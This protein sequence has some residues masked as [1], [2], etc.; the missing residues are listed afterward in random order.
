M[1]SLKLLP[2]IYLVIHALNWLEI[3]PGDARRETATWEQWP[4]RCEICYAYEQPLKEKYHALLGRPDDSSAVF[5]MPSGMAGD[6]P[7]IALAERT[8]GERCLV[9]PLGYD[10]G[11]NRSAL[12]EEFVR[13]ADA[14]RARAL[15]ARGSVTE[16]EIAAWERSKAWAWWFRRELE[17][18]GYTFDPETVRITA[19]GED[20]CGCAATFPIHMSRA[21]SLRHPIARRFDLMN[22]DCSRLLLEA[23]LVEQDV[24]L[25]HD[26][27]GLIVR[28]ANGQYV[29]QFHEGQHGLWERPHTVTLRFPVACV[30]RVNAQGAPLDAEPRAEVTLGVGCGGHTPWQAHFAMAEPGVSMEQFRAAVLAAEVAEVK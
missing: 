4:G 11:A 24:P 28:A 8:F 27:R 7:L 25:A 14:D 1:E 26:I 21:F 18:R 15:A 10:L 9:C 23:T 30:R 13:S 17:K 29:A 22:P 2:H 19:L 16:A 12:G 20:W 3:V 5:I 6:P